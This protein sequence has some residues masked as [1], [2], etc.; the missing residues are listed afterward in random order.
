M[1]VASWRLSPFYASQM[2]ILDGV[3]LLI[4]LWSL[5]GSKKSDTTDYLNENLGRSV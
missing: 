4:D 2:L 3:G 5:A 1:R